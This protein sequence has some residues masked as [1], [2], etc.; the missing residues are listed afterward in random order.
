MALLLNNGINTESVSHGS[1]A[2][3]DNPGALTIAAWVKTV[4]PLDGG[5]VVRKAN[6]GGSAFYGLYFETTG[7]LRVARKRG[8][9]DCAAQSQNGVVTANEW[10]FL[11]GT[12]NTSGVNTD[13]KLFRGALREIASEVSSYTTQSVGS[14]TVGDESANDLHVGNQFNTP[15]AWAALNATVGWVGVWDRQLTLDE[16]RQIQGHTLL[17]GEAEP[18]LLRGCVLYCWYGQY[19]SATEQ[20]F[21]GNKNHGVRVGGRLAFDPPFEWVSSIT[22]LVAGSQLMD[23]AGSVSGLGSLF[24]VGRVVRG[25]VGSVGGI[26][27]TAT[28]TV[29]VVL[30]FSGVA[31]AVSGL[32]ADPGSQNPPGVTITQSTVAAFPDRPASDGVGLLVTMGVGGEGQYLEHDMGVDMPLFYTRFLFNPVAVQGGELVI[33]VGIDAGGVETFRVV[34]DSDTRQLMFK[35]VTGNT[36]VHTLV[37]GLPWH[38]VEVKVDA[39]N[40]VAEMWVNGISVVAASGPFGFLKT[41]RVWLGGVFKD[42]NTHGQVYI[43]EWVTADQYIGPVVVEPSSLYA[44]DPASW[45]V[46]Y[47]A[48][49]PES[50]AWAEYY[51]GIRGIPF[52][53]LVGL[54]LSSAE[55]IGLAQWSSFYSA[56]VDYRVNNNLD[57]HVLGILLGY[58]VPGYVDVSGVGVVDPVPGL[59]HRGSGTPLFNPLAVD[60]VPE[61]P[62]RSNLSGF[63]LTARVDG[64]VLSEA[65]ALVSRATSL[66]STGLGD[67]SSSQIWFDPYAASGVSTDPPTASMLGWA[68]SLDRMR[69]RLPLVLSTNAGPQQETQFLQIQDDGFFW[70]WGAS[71]PP[72]GFYGSPAGSRV[73]HFQSDITSASGSTLRNSAVGDWVSSALGAGYAAAAGSSRSYSLSAIPF[74]RPF[75]EGIRRGWT[76]AESWFVANPVPGE[77][78]FLVGDP[79]MTV[80][81]P[82]LGWDVF[83]P[84]ERLE[85]LDPSTPLV[86]LREEELAVDL[87]GGM[88][89]VA[90]GHAVYLIR[91]LDSKGRSEMSVQAVRVENVGGQAVVPPLS[92]VW[93]DVDSWGVRIEGGVVRLALVWDRLT[94]ACGVLAVELEVDSVGSP[95]PSLQT[96]AVVPHQSVVQ[97][98]LLLPTQPTRYRW[99]VYGKGGGSVQTPWSEYVSDNTPSLVSLQLVE[100]NS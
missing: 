61:R 34:Y 73:F 46:V 63:Y 45:L 38:C 79:L 84:V 40:G 64:A 83:G 27:S 1:G 12:F 100:V 91:H 99:R 85:N 28:P 56:V 92:P 96:V 80:E 30:G 7:Y 58:Q 47:N 87:V 59:F 33:E 65:Q 16:I 49:V 41:R 90:G 74:V 13:Q 22:S 66:E 21:S 70:G 8:T 76:L 95:S 15:G 89:P 19:A 71:T 88:Q 5:F 69:T 62:T 86:A 77:G 39:V 44:D 78:L 35:L 81:T 6:A 18:L 23:V 24:G 93:P 29:G 55:T 50:I 26:S 2:S 51:R 4:S 75:F 9:S 60:A 97:T 42:V 10:Q 36:L 31:T 48:A 52:A 32:L 17:G 37:S 11:V 57:G 68:A 20:D 54:A 67:G 53:N 25:V 98:Q 82:R 43:D 3:L 72:S 94:G 14:G